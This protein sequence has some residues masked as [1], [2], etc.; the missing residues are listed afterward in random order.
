MIMSKATE[1][2]TGNR[3]PYYL[4]T[5]IFGTFIILLGIVGPLTVV[6]LWMEKFA[7]WVVYAASILIIIN[8]VMSGH[9][10]KL[11][12]ASG[13]AGLS[14]FSALDIVI[15]I[16]VSWMPLVADY[17]RFAKDSKGAFRGTL[18]GFAITNILFYFGGVLVG[19]S[20]VVAI[21]VAIQSIFFGFLLFMF[22]L[23]ETN[24]AFA[25]VYSSAV[26]TQSIFHKIKQR[27]LIIGFTALSTILALLIPISQYE[28]FIL[29]IGSVFVPL[30]GVVLS[31]YY[32]VKRRQY[33][34]DMMYGKNVL[35]IGFPAIVAWSFGVLLYYLLF[36]VSPIYIPQLSQIGAT[37]PSFVGS[38]LLYL[39]I[40]QRGKWIS[41]LERSRYRR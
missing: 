9:F 6:R 41:V 40:T 7:I 12:S 14:F 18:I 39:G 11:L 36:S 10:S 29:L 5:I 38:F 34:Q 15:A 31:D 3:I 21:I 20:D 16:P 2:L 28:T 26:S 4:W 1:I 8:L 30:F 13:G 37:I 19:N 22:I 33:T 24:N 27:Y 32:I 25:D 23:H 35:K 17:N